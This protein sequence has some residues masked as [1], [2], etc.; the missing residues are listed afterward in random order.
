M[1]TAALLAVCLFLLPRPAPADGLPP[2]LRDW[3]DQRD[4]VG[5]VTADFTQI[6]SLRGLRIPLRS[7]GSMAFDP[8]GGFRWEVGRP[9]R[10]LVVGTAAGMV[11]ADLRKRTWEKLGDESSAALA[12]P[13]ILA[14]TGSNGFAKAFEVASFTQGDAF[15]TARL[16]PAGGDMARFVRELSIAFESGSGHPAWIEVVGTDGS[17]VRTEFT[18]VRVGVS[19]E[20]GAFDFDPEGLREVTGG[21]SP[22]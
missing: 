10:I 14:A 9:P 15:S 7:E 1:K 5:A 11:L 21:G 22:R 16:K 4:K 20:E 8:D 3:I 13:R 2:A 18:N 19:L 6:R 12:V 17:S